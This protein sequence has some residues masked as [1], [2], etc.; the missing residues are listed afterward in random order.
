MRPEQW[1]HV[2]NRSGE[3]IRTCASDLRLAERLA[4]HMQV[5]EQNLLGVCVPVRRRNSMPHPP[6]TLIRSAALSR[7]L[8]HEVEQNLAFWPRVAVL[9]PQFAHEM[10][11]V[12]AVTFTGSSW[13]LW[14]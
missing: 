11:L 7:W 6:Q 3:D 2:P 10:T 5:R 8:A 12:A 14:R 1:A 13:P 9:T 4:A